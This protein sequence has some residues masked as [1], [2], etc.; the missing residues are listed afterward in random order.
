MSTV[1][2]Y[3]RAGCCLCEEAHTALARLRARHPFTLAVV[4]IAADDALH[5]R[6][7]ERIPVVAVDGCEAFEFEVDEASLAARL[8]APPSN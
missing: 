3:T 8:D 2:L 5:R 1:T 6:Y 7:L 4:D